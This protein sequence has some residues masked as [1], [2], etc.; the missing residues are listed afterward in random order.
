MTS[1]IGQTF[2][3]SR[4][5]MKNRTSRL[6]ALSLFGVLGRWSHTRSCHTWRLNCISIQRALFMG[7]ITRHFTVGVCKTRNRPGTPLD[8]LKNRGAP[9]PSGGVPGLFLVLQTSFQSEA[10]EYYNTQSGFHLTVERDWFWFWFWFYYAL[11]LA[12][13]LTLVLVLRQSSENRSNA[14][15]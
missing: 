5:W 7:R 10:T 1:A 11:W 3:S 8:R 4:I 2:L 15:I 14:K 6:T 9:S 13:V 12:S